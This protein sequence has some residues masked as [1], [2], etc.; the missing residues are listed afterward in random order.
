MTLARISSVPPGVDLATDPAPERELNAA[1]R[2]GTIDYAATIFTDLVLLAGA[3]T[4]APMAILSARCPTGDWKSLTEGFDT[5]DGLE[6]PA[7]F[8]LIVSRKGVI[9]IRDLPALPELA[10]IP[11]AR[12]PHSV[13]W[14]YATAMT[15]SDGTPIGTL[16]VCDRWP[17][18]ATPMESRALQAAA[19][20]ASD[21]LRRMV[22]PN[23]PE[24]LVPPPVPP[25]R[26]MLN[27]AEVAAL[28]GVSSRAVMY[29][30]RAG[31]LRALRT[32]G[33]HLHYS[34]RDVTELL[35]S[36]GTRSPSV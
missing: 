16:A 30:V 6:D 10:R 25:T 33:G 26:P 2:P 19:R 22:R 9:E 15:D 1:R 21:Y 11:L 29:W 20:V 5:H 7:L 3:S 27:T 31:K 17:R 23:H 18:K 36:R 12:P 4:N 13:R 35:A 32:P 8:D 14:V 28:F 24:P 34:Q